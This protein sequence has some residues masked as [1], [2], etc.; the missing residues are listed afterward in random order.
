MYLN[1]LIADDCEDDALLIVRELRKSGYEPQF[2]RVETRAGMEQALEQ[3]QTAPGGYFA[4][5][6]FEFKVVAQLHRLPRLNMLQSVDSTTAFLMA[7]IRN[8]LRQCR[9]KAFS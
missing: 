7:S 4:G 3:R 1:V 5:G 8:H 6:E 9:R 2:E